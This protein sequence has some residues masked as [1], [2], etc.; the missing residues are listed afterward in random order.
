VDFSW[1]RIEQGS[2][3]LKCSFKG[4]NF[5]RTRFDG[6]LFDWCD[7]A[8]TDFKSACV[9][10]SL[11]RNSKNDTAV[12]NRGKGDLTLFVNNDDSPLRPDDVYQP[13]LY[14]GLPRLTI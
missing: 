8:D 4:A 14:P 1:A 12:N 11:V 3:F 9:S 10:T 13:E 7:F 2:Y 6:V 5:T